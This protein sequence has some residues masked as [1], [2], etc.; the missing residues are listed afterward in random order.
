VGMEAAVDVLAVIKKLF[1]EN[2][3]NQYFGEPVSQLEHALQ[4]AHLAVGSNASEALVVA[5]LLHDV[6]HLVH[7]QPESI[8]GAGIDARHEVEGCRFL[9]QYFG[10]E[11]VEPVRLHV[12]AKRYLC[13]MDEEYAGQLS[14]ASVL[15]LE[16][17]GGPM[18]TAEAAEF[19]WT[20]HAHD[21]VLLRVWDD[22]AKVP[23]LEVPPLDTYLPRIERV[24]RRAGTCTSA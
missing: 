16:L 13:A 17:Q 23:G 12:A 2:G 5:A 4:T 24:L 18:S 8:A 19:A 22:Q 6:G 20:P 14:L 10:R 15:S 9:S 21:A 3:A 11:V 7:G 1:A